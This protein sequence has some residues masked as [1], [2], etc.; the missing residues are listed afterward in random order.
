MTRG[1]VTYMAKIFVTLKPTVNDPQGLTIK[2][3]LRSLGFDSV[4]DVRAGKLIEVMMSEISEEVA[5]AKTKEM[6]RQLL[7]NPVIENYRFQIQEVGAGATST[8]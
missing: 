1:T 5:E 4:L 6:C 8:K 2:G 3:A 7:A